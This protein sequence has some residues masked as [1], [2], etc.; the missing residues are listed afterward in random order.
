MVNRGTIESARNIGTILVEVIVRLRVNLRMYIT[1]HSLKLFQSST[2][3][4]ASA[5][6][7]TLQ[8]CFS[9][10]RQWHPLPSAQK[11]KFERINIQIHCIF[12]MSLTKASTYK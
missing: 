10:L 7:K 2:S 6:G 11:K 9:I 4:K 12:K 3:L 1:S 8:P 5:T